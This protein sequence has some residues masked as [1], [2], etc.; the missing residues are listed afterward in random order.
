MLADRT[1]QGIGCVKYDLCPPTAAAAAG[2]QL[3]DTYP[4]PCEL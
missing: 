2:F 4:E 3:N 1:S